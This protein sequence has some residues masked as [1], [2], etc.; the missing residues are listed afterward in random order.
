MVYSNEDRTKLGIAY[1]TDGKKWDKNSKYEFSI[2]MTSNKY[3]QINYPFLIK[4]NNEYRLYYTAT[5]KGNSM[6]ICLA[7]ASKL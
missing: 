7:Q 1:S 3:S 4:V 2:Q 6:Q 5:T